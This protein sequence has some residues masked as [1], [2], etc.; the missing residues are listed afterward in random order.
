MYVQRWGSGCADTWPQALAIQ[1]HPAHA[2]IAL[3]Q[4]AE[5]VDNIWHACGDTS[6]DY[7]WYTKRGLLAAV[8]AATELFILTDYSPG[9]ADTWRALDRRLAD[10]KRLGGAATEVTLCNV[11]NAYHL[12][13]FQP[14]LLLYFQP[15]KEAC[16]ICGSGYQKV[17]PA[18]EA[19]QICGSGYQKEAMQKRYSYL[20][21]NFCDAPHDNWSISGYLCVVGSVAGAA[22]VQ[23]SAGKCGIDG[24]VGS[25]CGDTG[26]EAPPAIKIRML[27]QPTTTTTPN[28]WP[29]QHGAL[30]A[31]LGSNWICTTTRHQVEAS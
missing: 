5:L 9:Y 8:Y 20:S 16:Q 3:Q 22:G 2:A 12:Q 7:N 1:A 23:Q 18:K 14:A 13:C 27:T 6:T 30:V 25:R 4:R 29:S 11:L 10:V 19:C 28:C 15:A 24:R 26:P 31:C 21:D 17:Q